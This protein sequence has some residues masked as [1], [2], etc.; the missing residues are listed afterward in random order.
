MGAEPKPL[1]PVT[2]IVALRSRPMRVWLGVICGIAVCVGPGGAGGARTAV[3]ALLLPDLDQRAP[4]QV[5][6]VWGGPPGHLQARLAFAT[7]VE[8]LG[9]GPLVVLGERPNLRVKRMRAE[10]Y[11]WRRSGGSSKAT[12][13]RGASSR[14]SRSVTAT[15]TRR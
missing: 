6:V 3:P 10:Q 13:A 15:S 14:G 12:R 2:P 11:V 1:H 4:Q 5:Q 9:W 7:N 8:D